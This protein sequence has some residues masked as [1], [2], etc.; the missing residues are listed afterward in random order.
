MRILVLSWEYPPHIVGGLGKHVADLV[1]ALARLGVE[2]HVVTPTFGAGPYEEL[3]QGIS[4]HRTRIPLLASETH[5]F[6]TKA[7]YT[8]SLLDATCERLHIQYGL[9]DLIHNH[10]WLTSFAAISLKRRYKTPMLA[11]IH[12][13]ERGR[14]R[15]H[16][17]DEHSRRIDEAEWRLVYEAWRVICCAQYMAEEVRSYFGVPLDKADVIPNG[18]DA[19][20]FDALDGVD[21]SAFRG[22]YARP[23]EQI[24]LYVGRLVQEKGVEILIR[25]AP[26]VL[27]EIPTARFVIAGKGPELEPLRQLVDELGLRSRILCPGFIDDGDRDRL[28]KVADCA[29]FP[30]LYEPFGIV[31]LEAMAARTPVVVSEVGGLKEVV[32]HAETGITVYPGDPGSCAWGIV[33]TLQHP[34]WAKQRVANAYREVLTVFNWDTIAHQT[35]AVYERVLEERRKSDW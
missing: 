31:A 35:L 25:A 6:Y 20:P 1:P 29:V 8:N 22:Q 13:T 4:V 18:V 28:Y 30:S 16:L 19:S 26:Q 7:L 23:D 14:G 21:L 5:D 17:Y 27:R 9:F 33:H 11:T 3:S 12:A 34:E 10:D 32:R 15:G 2:V 24:V